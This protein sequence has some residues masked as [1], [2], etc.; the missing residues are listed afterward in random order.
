MPARTGVV[1]LLIAM[2][3]QRP[4][5]AQEAGA[6]DGSV[7]F[8]ADFRTAF[9]IT[10]GDGFADRPVFHA[11]G[12]V[13]LGQ[14][15]PGGPPTVAFTLGTALSVGEFLGPS[16]IAVRVLGGIELPVALGAASGPA[17]P[18]ELVPAI[19]AGY[20]NAFGEDRRSGFTL[21]AALGLRLLSR[22]SG[23]YFTV[24]PVS[25]VLLPRPDPARDRGSERLAVELGLLKFGVR[26]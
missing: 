20:Q 12:G 24:E 2:L 13:Q 16:P 19:Q 26:W 8:L 15:V 9:M 17:K 4:G 18:P 11:S 7:L 21:R 1:V 23:F 3:L 10:G 5:V 25:L 22:E 14:A 6:S